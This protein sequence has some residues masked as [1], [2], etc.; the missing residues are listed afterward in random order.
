MA[1]IYALY[2]IYYVLWYLKDS[3][4]NC[5]YSKG[6]NR[7]IGNMINVCRAKPPVWYLP[8]WCLSDTR[9]VFL[10]LH[11]SHC[12][13]ALEFTGSWEA[14]LHITCSLV[15]VLLILWQALAQSVHLQP[16]LVQWNGR[17]EQRVR[18]TLTKWTFVYS[19]QKKCI[20]LNHVWHMLARSGIL[21]LR[22]HSFRKSSQPCVACR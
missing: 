22:D 15:C 16:W 5:I 2:A 8:Y 17:S 20:L 18:V 4:Y 19:F 13:P 9:T 10:T 1:I 21:E 6:G 14:Y 7:D 11:H 12:M 3:L